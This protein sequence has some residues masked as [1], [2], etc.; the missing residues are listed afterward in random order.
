MRGSIGLAVL[1]ALFAATPAFATG[2]PEQRAACSDDAF[3]FCNDYVPDAFAVE[4]CLRAHIS[5][6]SPA[7]RKELGAPRKAK[8][9]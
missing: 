7:C 8:R 1:V 9:S 5:E 2:T 4:R 6:L 3:R